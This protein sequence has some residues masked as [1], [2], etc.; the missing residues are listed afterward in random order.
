MT[1]ILPTN[2]AIIAGLREGAGEYQP[3]CGTSLTLIVTKTGTFVGNDPKP[4]LEVF[5]RKIDL[6]NWDFS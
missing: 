5:F 1:L 4:G 2:E 3:L 6:G